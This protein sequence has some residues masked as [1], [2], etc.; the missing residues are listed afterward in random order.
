VAYERARASDPNAPYALT[1]LCYLS[2]LEGRT[3]AALRECRQALKLDPEAASAHNNL[4]LIYASQGRLDLAR[5]E[6]FRSGDEASAQFNI[7]VIYMATK[8]YSNA[9]MAFQAALG[10]RPSFSAAGQ[11]AR[12]A[13][14]LAQ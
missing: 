5:L 10:A 7:G 4:A 14:A 8:D 13:Q 2:F 11:R 12:Q 6:L 3:D 9:A 1:N